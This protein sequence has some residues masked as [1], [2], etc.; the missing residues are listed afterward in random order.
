METGTS[1]PQP[2]ENGGEPT[3][4]ATAEPMEEVRNYFYHSFSVFLLI[5]L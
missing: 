2:T 4:P 1:A 3:T 5:I